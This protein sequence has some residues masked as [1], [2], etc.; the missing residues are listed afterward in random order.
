MKLYDFDSAGVYNYLISWNR[1]EYDDSIF[2]IINQ[3]GPVYDHADGFFVSCFWNLDEVQNYLSEY[4]VSADI[5]ISE[6]T[7]DCFY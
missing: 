2:H 6:I 5:Q 1:G 3:F 4:M 7:E